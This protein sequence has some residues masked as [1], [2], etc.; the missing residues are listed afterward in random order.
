MIDRK[1]NEKIRLALDNDTLK[2]LNG[3]SKLTH[4]SKSDIMRASIIYCLKNKIIPEYR[5]HKLETI[6]TIRITIEMK[7]YFNDLITDIKSRYTNECIF[8]CL[9]KK[10]FKIDDIRIYSKL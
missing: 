3:Y 10:V 6:M 8:H 2:L 7:G 5:T 1:F 4:I 9:T